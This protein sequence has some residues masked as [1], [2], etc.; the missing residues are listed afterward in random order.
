MKVRYYGDAPVEGWHDRTLEL[1]RSIHDDHGVTVEIDRV[2]ARYGSLTAFAGEV[3]RSTAQAVYERDLKHNRDLIDSIDTRPSRAYKRSG[4]LAIAGNVAVVDGEG[5]VRWASTRPGY[6]DGY[7]LGAER[8]TAMDFLEAVAIAPSNR[9]CVDC[10]R[11]L[12][13]DERYCPG[14]G[15]ELGS[16]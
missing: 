13:G 1:L 15:R 16:G 8:Q 7:G 14:C 4:H 6:A 12:D 9:L 3:R 11:R 5:T 2:A 10:L